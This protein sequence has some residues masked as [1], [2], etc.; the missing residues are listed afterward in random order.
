M[1]VSNL[2]SDT[3]EAPR[4]LSSVQLSRLGAIAELHGGQVPLHGRLFAQWMHHAFPRE[5]PFP[6]M[7]GSTS[8]LSHEEWHKSTGGDNPLATKEEMQRRAAELEAMAPL[9]DLRA[10][11]WTDVEE[12][13]APSPRASELGWPLASL[14][15]AVILAALVSSALPLA[16]AAR[17]SAP[18]LSAESKAE[19]YLV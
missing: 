13:L 1:V 2:E 11:P 18:S 5:C 17:G 10:L 9:Q 8:A 14:R 7:S 16:R 6:H 12:L 19:R 3:V 15:S 4:N